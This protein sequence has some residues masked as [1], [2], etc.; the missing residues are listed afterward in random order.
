M[1]KIL[2][3]GEVFF[4]YRPKVSAGEVAG[5]DDVQRFFCFLKPDRRRWFRNVIVGRKRLPDPEEHEREWAFVYEVTDN[6]AELREEIEEKEYETKTRGVRRQP[7]A[8]PVGEGRYAV[9]NHDGH[10]HLAYVLELPREPGEA[11]R[12]FNIREEA[13]FIV[14]VRNPE[15]PARP[16][17][18]LPDRRRADLPGDLASRFEGRRFIALEP[19]DFLDHEGVEL[20]LIGAAEDAEEELGIDLDIEHESIEDA[21][22]FRR[23]RLKPDEVPVEPLAEGR[24][25]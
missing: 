22:I 15:A 18:G 8:R 17:V 14:A 19:P 16:G 5:I 6:P 24:L 3:K 23:L 25:R 2:E 7:Q 12:T 9:V 13:S 4:F 10:T 11:Q 21:A 20:V 1:S